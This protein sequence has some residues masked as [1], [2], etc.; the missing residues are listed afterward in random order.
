MQGLK[1]A[2]ITACYGEELNI[3]RCYLETKKVFETRLPSYRYEHIF[4]DNC[5]T[6]GTIPLL[7]RIAAEDPNVKV[8]LNA[9][10]YGPNRS[11]FNALMEVGSDVSAVLVLLSAD[12]QDPPNLIPKFVEKWEQG[13][14]VV[15]GV[16]S[17]REEQ[18][19]LRGIRKIYYRLVR[20]LSDIELPLDSGE[21]Q[22]IDRCVLDALKKYDDHYPYIRGMVANCGFKAIGIPFDWKARKHGVSKTRW[23]NLIDQ[24]LNGL[25]STTN[26]PLRICMFFGLAVA[27]L[28]M[29]YAFVN[30]ILVFLNVGD[31]KVAGVPTLIVSQFFLG[32]VQLFIL[33]FIGEYIGSIHSAVRKKPLVIVKERIN[34]VNSD[35][36][37]EFTESL[38]DSKMLL[39]EET[40]LF[41]GQGNPELC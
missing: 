12:L 21:F 36:E 9:R 13:Y 6:D 26:L 15:S 18:L 41:E 17:N 20:G 28:S 27:L 35:Q 39:K 19:L 14:Q 7:R 29:M 30:V 24:G 8:I 3:E 11:N 40:S 34:F 22:L 25:I 5:S 37:R 31:G 4:A 23:Y 33:G 38:S 1:L 10:N 32:G 16:R 2:V